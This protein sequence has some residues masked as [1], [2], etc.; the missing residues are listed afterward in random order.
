MKPKLSEEPKKL[1]SI[2]TDDELVDA[3]WAA[4]QRPSPAV[5][6]N[7]IAGLFREWEGDYPTVKDNSRQILAEH[8]A[9]V[10]RVIARF[11]ERWALLDEGK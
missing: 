11:E 6:R 9:W 10:D 3:I 7:E 1:A 4:I 8:R 5:T 2:V